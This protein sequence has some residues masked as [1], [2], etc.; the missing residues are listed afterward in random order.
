MKIRKE[1]EIAG[2]FIL[3]VLLLG[4]CKM[5]IKETYDHTVDYS[6]YKTFCWMTGCEFKFNGPEYLN[7][8]LLRESLKSSL[9]KELES[10]GLKEDPNNPDLLVGFTITMQ[11]EQAIIYHRAEDSPVYYQPLDTEREVINYLK[12]TLIIGMADNKESRMVWQSQAISYMELNPDFSEKNIHKGI[13]LVLKNFPP[14]PE[15]K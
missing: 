7:D 1:I 5:E 4:S 9:I 12:G 13:K 10:E 2:V 14:K 11:D 8:S 6:K 15:P 3:F